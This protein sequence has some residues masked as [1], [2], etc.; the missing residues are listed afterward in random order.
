[1]RNITKGEFGC[2][3]SNMKII[4]NFEQN[5][6]YLLILEDDADFD[7]D[8]IYRISQSITELKNKNMY[9]DSI[10]FGSEFMLKMK[11]I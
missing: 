3:N 5:D 2:Y 11:V 8:F 9:W 6:K 7:S 4:K 1:M 10:N